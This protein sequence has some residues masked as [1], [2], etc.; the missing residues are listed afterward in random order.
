M[1]KKIAENFSEPFK[2]H[3]VNEIESG[4]ILKSE[5]NKKYGILGHSTIA[6]WCKIYGKFSNFESKGKQTMK[7]VLRERDLL[8]RNEI[9]ALKEELSTARLKNVVLET[10]ID[11][12]DDTLDTNIRK[13]FGAKRSGK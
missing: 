7:T 10:M 3:L 5:A 9:K 13:K 6:K 1:N 11:I 4:I 12:A 8:L 2:I